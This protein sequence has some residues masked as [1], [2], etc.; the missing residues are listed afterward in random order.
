MISPEEIDYVFNIDDQTSTV[1]YVYYEKDKDGNEVRKVRNK[2][3]PR[4]EGE[5]LAKVLEARKKKM[6]KL[7][8]TIEQKAP[9]AKKE[10]FRHVAAKAVYTPDG[11][12]VSMADLMK[13]RKNGQ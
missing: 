8:K 4:A 9:E 11:R 3:V 13:V 5:Q 12:I 6:E 7:K 2:T 1:G 10:T